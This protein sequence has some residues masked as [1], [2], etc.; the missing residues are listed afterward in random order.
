VIDGIIATSRGAIAVEVKL[1]KDLRNW[2][3]RVTSAAYHLLAFREAA[4]G[5]YDRLSVLVAVVV[6]NKRTPFEMSRRLR[7]LRS[8]HPEMDVRVFFLPELLEKYGVSEQL[9]PMYQ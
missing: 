5:R 9:D 2:Q 6:D 3:N 7:D 8:V 1:V 4:K